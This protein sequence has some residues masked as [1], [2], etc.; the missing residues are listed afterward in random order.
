MANRESELERRE[1]EIEARQADLNKRESELDDREAQQAAAE[2]RMGEPLVAGNVCNTNVWD[3]DN[4]S[5]AAEARL[6]FEEH[7]AWAAEA[8]V[9][10]IIAETFGFYGEAQ[11]ALDAIQQG[12]D[13]R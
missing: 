2:W 7:I 11:V 3:P 1:S 10:F 6:M 4:A 8:G 5:T 12:L 9:D 13:P